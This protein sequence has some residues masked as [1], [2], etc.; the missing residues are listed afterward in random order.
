MTSI[1]L[2]QF[3]KD[4]RGALGKVRRGQSLLLTLRGKPVARLEPV[5]SRPSEND[6]IYRLADLA[7]DQGTSLTNDEM[8]RLIYDA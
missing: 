1:S 7:T 4:A 2:V 8:D 3:R 5:E 6:P